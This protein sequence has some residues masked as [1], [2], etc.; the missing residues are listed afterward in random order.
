MQNT[1]SVTLQ[2][3]ELSKKPCV[4]EVSRELGVHDVNFQGYSLTCN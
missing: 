4:L 2:K 3:L 1:T